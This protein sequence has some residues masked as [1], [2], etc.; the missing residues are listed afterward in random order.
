MIEPET[1]QIEF[2]SGIGRD[3]SSSWWLAV[4][5]KLVF[6]EKVSRQQAHQLQLCSVQGRTVWAT[7][8]GQQACKGSRSGRESTT[9]TH[10]RI[11]E[12]ATMLELICKRT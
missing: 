9:H 4:A 7:L 1:R 6:S 5:S 2:T 10:Q 3:T 11:P 8:K 12:A